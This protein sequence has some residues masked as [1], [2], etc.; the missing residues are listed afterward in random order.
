MRRDFLQGELS[1]KDVLIP[2]SY[3]KIGETCEKTL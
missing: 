1:F 2:L 3:S